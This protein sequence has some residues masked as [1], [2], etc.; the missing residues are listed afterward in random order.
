MYDVFANKGSG[1]QEWRSGES[2]RLPMWPGFDSQ[3]RRHMWVEFFDSVLCTE[4][5]SP[6]TPLSPLLKKQNTVMSNSLYAVH[7]R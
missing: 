5:F 2:T 3:I 4:R 7:L 6:G 1:V